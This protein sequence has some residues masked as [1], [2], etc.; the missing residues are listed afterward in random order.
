MP[1]RPRTKPELPSRVQGSTPPDADPA[2]PPDAAADPAASNKPPEAQPDPAAAQPEAARD[3]AADSIS[4]AEIYVALNAVKKRKDGVTIGSIQRGIGV[5][6]KRAAKIL[7]EMEKRGIVG[8]KPKPGK[9]RDILL[10]NWDYI[11]APPPPAEPEPSPP[12]PPPEPA[13]AEPPPEEPAPAEP[14]PSEPPPETPE[15]PPAAADTPPPP[16]APGKSKWESIKASFTGAFERFASKFRGET[17]PQDEKKYKASWGDVAKNAATGFL[18]VA[19]SYTGTKIIVDLPSWIYQKYWTNPAERERLK[20]SFA[21]KETESTMEHPAAVDQRKARLEQAINESKFL[22]KEKKT[23]LLSKLQASVESYKTAAETARRE[24]SEAIAKLLDQAIETRIKNTQVLKEG[25]NSALMVTGLSAMRGVA[26]GTVAI[27]ERHQEVM[28]SPERRAQYF[29]EMTYRGFTETAYNLI[30]GKA[31][32]WTGKGMNFVKGATN[33]LRAAGFTDLAIAEWTSEGRSF[34]SVIETSLKAF[35]D[36]GTTTAAWENIKMPWARLGSEFS[37]ATGKTTDMELSPTT[38]TAPVP[39]TIA[40]DTDTGGAPESGVD[41]DEDTD[42]DTDTSRGPADTTTGVDA[43]T[44]PDATRPAPSIEVPPPVPV[45]EAPPD[46]ETLE[47]TTVRKGDGFLR[48]FHRQGVDDDKA[49]QAAREAGI[50]RAGGDTRL[51]TQAI[52]RL[53]VFGVEQPNG[54]VEIKIFDTQTDKYLTLQEARAAGFTYESGSAPSMTIAEPGGSVADARVGSLESFV[55]TP[56]VPHELVG[57]KMEIIVSDGRL[58]SLDFHL[59]R[60]TDDQTRNLEGIYATPEMETRVAKT[61]TREAQEIATRLVEAKTILEKLEE[62]GKGGTEE[63]DLLRTQLSRDIQEAQRYGNTIFNETALQP[64]ATAGSGGEVESVSD[65]DRITNV[66]VTGIGRVTFTYDAAG[67]PSLDFAR[68]VA[69]A[70]PVIGTKAEE[71]LAQNW[72]DTIRTDVAAEFEKGRELGGTILIITEAI[73]ELEAQGHGETTEARFIR[74]QLKIILESPDGQKLSAEHPV[75]KKAV[76]L[77]QTRDTATV[78][79]RIPPE[80]VAPEPEEPGSSKPLKMFK[81]EAGRVR[82]VY[83]KETGAV[84]DAFLPAYTPKPREI[85][86]ALHDF[87]LTN[88]KVERHFFEGASRAHMDGTKI[89]T[90]HLG[91]YPEPNPTES[92][93]GFPIQSPENDYRQFTKN[94]TDAQRMGQLMAEMIEQ[95]LQNTPEFEKLKSETVAQ[96]LEVQRQIRKLFPKT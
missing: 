21:V 10:P 69:D 51:T 73:R 33:V 1:I 11:Q 15:P 75:V 53:S 4:D 24:Q 26:Y 92:R 3:T 29:R 79:T 48:I 57:G 16:P 19:A 93:T 88:E 77:T 74:E 52:G 34:S 62:T 2:A 84:K 28:K 12:E 87:G 13:P 44:Q 20:A 37:W 47:R 58:Q 7:A 5:S 25:L 60:L 72:K 39:G 68:L 42:V 70:K 83:D 54:E 50:V 78:G 22:S 82:F 56:D 80:S 96:G 86:D 49:L 31:E 95:G 89:E 45:P 76:A 32:T 64:Y 30:G 40:P 90:S 61:F 67:K 81:G 17:Q 59:D 65:A 36:K 66:Q 46:T 18:S 8:P 71:L 14:P 94:V 55:A 43:D 27:G 38:P 23:E 63:A 9:K 35:E 6:Q 85:E 91:R 41:L